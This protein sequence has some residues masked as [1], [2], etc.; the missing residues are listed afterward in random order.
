[1]SVSDIRDP[2]SVRKA[3]EEYDRLGRG[4]FLSRYGFHEAR[5][6]LLYLDG[7]TYD[8]KAIVGVAHKFEFPEEGPLA[9]DTFSGGLATVVRKLNELGF[10]VR[11]PDDGPRFTPGRTYSRREEIHKKYGG[12]WQSGIATP[13]DQ[14]CIFIFTSGSGEQFGYRDEFKSDGVFW[15]TGEGQVGDMSMTGGNL[16]LRDHAR[17]GKAIHLFESVATGN[18]QYV[19]RFEYLGHHTEDRPDKNGD[20]RKAIVFE[21]GLLGDSP[22]GSSPADPTLPPSRH[23]M[24]TRPLSE[25]RE[26]AAAVSNSSVPARERRSIVHIRSESV[27]VYVLRRA[28][29]VCECCGKPAPFKRRDGRPYLE[30]H[31][32]RRVADGG[33]DDPRW[34]AAICPNCHRE[35]HHGEN[36][37][38]LNES[39]GK[40]LAELEPD[41]AAD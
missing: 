13:A 28:D 15:Y 33:P 10:E 14:P 36:G 1:M 23:R 41:R 11:G 40:R 8:S 24:W 7:K 18:V 12:Q 5:D 32:L 38:K 39:L 25:L 2:E 30:P 17:A 20:R 3:V 19:G 21:L 26:L 31:H 35:I 6:Y 34:V 16:A 4:E 9:A 29:G 22:A 37:E 27:K